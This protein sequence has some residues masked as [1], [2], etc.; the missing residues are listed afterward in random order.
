MLQIQ[1]PSDSNNRVGSVCSIGYCDCLTSEVLVYNIFHGEEF[2]KSK[3]RID[4]G[5]N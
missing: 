3:H 5:V 4:K 2:T 1:T